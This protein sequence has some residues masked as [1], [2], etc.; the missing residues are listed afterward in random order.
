MYLE[1]GNAIHIPEKNSTIDNVPDTKYD[2]VD[3]RSV[4]VGSIDKFKAKTLIANSNNTHLY[5]NEIDDLYF[6][7]D[8]SYGTLYEIGYV[9]G[10]LSKVGKVHIPNNNKDKFTKLIE[11][12]GE[13][14]ESIR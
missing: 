11:L 12:F 6:T 2:L 1:T 3:A 8:A 10:D 9:H 13:D 14:K 4:M 5:V 7:Y